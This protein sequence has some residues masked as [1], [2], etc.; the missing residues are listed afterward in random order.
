MY[1]HKILVYVNTVI[2]IIHIIIWVCNI[3]SKNVKPTIFFQVSESEEYQRKLH[4]DDMPLNVQY[5][6]P[7]RSDFIF[8]LKRN[9]NYQSK[10][11]G[12]QFLDILFCIFEILFI[13]WHCTCRKILRERIKRPISN[14]MIAKVGSFKYLFRALCTKK[15][16]A[17]W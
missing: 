15:I 5:C 1:L 3:C 16:G 2:Y 6:W 8:L 10:K 12:F 11:V 7:Y 9:P 4:H 14:G 17:L 13:D